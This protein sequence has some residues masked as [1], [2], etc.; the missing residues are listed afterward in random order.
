M[1]MK[2]Q[3]ETTLI[4]SSSAGNHRKPSVDA[5]SAKVEDPKAR[6]GRKTAHAQPADI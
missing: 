6:K 3:P 5:S 1:S 4:S 2:Y